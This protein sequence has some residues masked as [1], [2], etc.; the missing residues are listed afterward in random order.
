MRKFVFCLVTKNSW[1]IARQPRVANGFRYTCFAACFEEEFISESGTKERDRK[2][3]QWLTCV[4]ISLSLFP[5][6]NAAQTTTSVIKMK[7]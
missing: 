3:V 1:S 2:R 5:R 7:S 4:S 6:K